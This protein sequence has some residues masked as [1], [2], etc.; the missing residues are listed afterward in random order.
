MSPPLNYGGKVQPPP[1]RRGCRRD[2]YDPRP[3][4]TDPRRCRVVVG[5][6]ILAR[7]ARSSIPLPPGMSRQLRSTCRAMPCVVGDAE[8]PRCSNALPILAAT[9]LARS[10]GRRP[11]P[12]YVMPRAE[13]ASRQALRLFP[14][15]TVTGNADGVRPRCYPALSCPMRSI[16]HANAPSGTAIRS[17]RRSLPGIQRTPRSPAA[18]LVYLY[19]DGERADEP[20]LQ[21]EAFKHCR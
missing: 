13:H 15:A 12:G 2:D 21:S 19:P 20:A 18:V 3:G 17:T 1:G 7:C 14:R 16:G 8:R 4:P 6:P 5:L 10:L 9:P 11:P